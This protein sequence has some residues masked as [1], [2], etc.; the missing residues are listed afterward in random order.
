MAIIAAFENMDLTE[1]KDKTFL[2]SIKTNKSDDVPYVSKLIKGPFYFYEMVE[3]CGQIWE[4]QN[5]HPF[6]IIA[7]KEFSEKIQFLDDDTI[8]YLETRWKDIVTDGFLT[9][10][11]NGDYSCKATIV[12][13][14]EEKKGE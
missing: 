6:V 14:E 3:M 9:D 7:S 2:M 5:R 1:L 11:L 8:D 12:E 13:Y 10:I 4:N